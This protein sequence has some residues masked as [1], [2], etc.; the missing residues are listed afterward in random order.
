MA[1]SETVTCL[2]AALLHL[3]EKAIYNQKLVVMHIL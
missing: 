1:V 3:P 2:V